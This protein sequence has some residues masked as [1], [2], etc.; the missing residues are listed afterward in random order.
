M[1]TKNLRY[2]YIVIRTDGRPFTIRSNDDLFDN[3]WHALAQ[4]NSLNWLFVQ[5]WDN[6]RHMSTIYNHE[7][8]VRL[9]F[10]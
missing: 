6:G 7:T 1:E 9:H 3:G 2:E 5:Q 10:R 4:R 8:D